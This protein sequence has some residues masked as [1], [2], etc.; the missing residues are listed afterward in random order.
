LRHIIIPGVHVEKHME[1]KAFADEVV[2]N[3]DAK[4]H[5]V[6]DLG[7]YKSLQNF[8]LFM[9]H[10]VGSSRVKQ[11]KSGTFRAF[12]DSLIGYIPEGSFKLPTILGK[13][14]ANTPK[15]ETE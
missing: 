14:A 13:P 3:L 5:L 7:V 12:S 2:K 4:F 1:A 15:I 8:S 11:Y 10:K 6:I 9:N